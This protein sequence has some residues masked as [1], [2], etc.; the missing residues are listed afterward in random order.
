M[1]KTL[2]S[3]IIFLLLAVLICML[4]RNT[5]IGGITVYGIQGLS[6]ENQELDDKIQTASKLSS[7][8]YQEALSNLSDSV[9]E[10]KS[11]KENYEEL[12]ALSTTDEVGE[13]SQLE[14]YEIEY[15]WARIGKHATDENVVLK[16]D[17]SANSTSEATGYYDLE[18]TAAGSYVG[19]TDFIYDIENDSSLGFKIENFKMVP[20]SSTD[21]LQA[22][23]TCTDISINID[24]SSVVDSSEENSDGETTNDSEST[25]TNTTNTTT[26]NTTTSN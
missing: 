18:F 20:G 24:Y 10:F 3:A 13:A 9:K 15:L 16:L 14:T 12:V 22:T 19:L 17:I 4:L 6:E 21:S 26:T 1:R 23:F 5:T 7:T 11:A 2:I 25:N 8:D